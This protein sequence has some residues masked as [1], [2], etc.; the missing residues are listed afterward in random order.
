MTFALPSQPIRLGVAL[1][2]QDAWVA[3]MLRLSGRPVGAYEALRLNVLR[4]AAGTRHGGPS[5]N[6]GLAPVRSPP[7]TG[8]VCPVIQAASVEAREATA[9]A[10]S[11]GFPTRPSG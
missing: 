5:W 9:A 1:R 7:S 10:M 6:S 4:R 3:T 11:S 2:F 8:S